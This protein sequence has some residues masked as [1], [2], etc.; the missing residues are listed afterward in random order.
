MKDMDNS[1]KQLF[2]ARF[3]DFR[4][5]VKKDLKKLEDLFISTISEFRNV[6]KEYKTE[7]E[8]IIKELTDRINQNEKDIIKLQ[9]DIKTINAVDKK[10]DTTKNKLKTDWRIVLFF[11]ITIIVAIGGYV[12]GVIF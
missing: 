3:N 4:E 12:V 6:T 11:I 9:G 7:K 5:D 2:E 8:I 10:E 1:D